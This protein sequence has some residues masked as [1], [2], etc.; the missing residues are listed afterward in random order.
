MRMAKNAFLE[1][2]IDMGVVPP[3]VGWL[4]CSLQSLDHLVGR[5]IEIPD[6]CA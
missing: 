6:G 5:P 1:I 2:A 4:E 3:E